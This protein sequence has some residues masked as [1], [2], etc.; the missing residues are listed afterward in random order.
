MSSLVLRN[1]RVGS[2]AQWTINETVQRLLDARRRWTVV[3]E[4]QAANDVTI[5]RD[6]DLHATMLDGAC[7]EKRVALPS[8][9]AS[10]RNP[11]GPW[12]GPGGDTAVAKIGDLH[13]E[14]A[15]P[16]AE[17]PAAHTTTFRLPQREHS[18]VARA[19]AERGSCDMAAVAVGSA[20]SPYH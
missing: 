16:R 4:Q 17:P 1:V 8:E 2:F 15:R 7:Y 5:D 9:E 10:H 14:D 11:G 19:N 3:P 20:S 6:L 18:A 13:R 12:R